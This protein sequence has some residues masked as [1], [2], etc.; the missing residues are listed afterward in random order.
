[1]LQH[2][3]RFQNDLQKYTIAIDNLQD[4]QLKSQATRLL[5]DLIQAV[6][7]LDN[8]YVDMVYAKQLPSMGNEMRD[9]I[10]QIR[11][12]LDQLVKKS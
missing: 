3:E 6:K 2:N 7:E 8:R 11:R 12:Q 4:T 5:N 9:K 10:T 1:M